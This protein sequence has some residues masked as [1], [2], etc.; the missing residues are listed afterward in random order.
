M[1]HVASPIKPYAAKPVQSQPSRPPQA[2]D[3]PQEAFAS[4][5]DDNAPETAAAAKDQDAA[6]ACAPSTPK[7]KPGKSNPDAKPA[8][9]QA[10]AKPD[11][12]DKADK[13]D[14]AEK[15]EKPAIDTNTGEAAA[16]TTD[17]AAGTEKSGSTPA[18]S[19]APVTPD[20]TAA[21]AVVPVQTIVPADAQAAATTN[22]ASAQ[23]P[24]IAAPSGQKPLD[25]AGLEG[26]A[27]KTDKVG[28][29][30]GDDP[31]ADAPQ[32]TYGEQAAGKRAAPAKPADGKTAPASDADKDHIARARGEGSDNPHR[33][34]K[35]N[36]AVQAD[37][38]AAAPKSTPDVPTP[39]LHSSSP[40]ATANAATANAAVTTPAAAQTPVPLAGVAVEIASKAMD[41]KKSFEIRLDPP[42]L[43]RI[44]VHMN[45]D[46]DGNVTSRLIADR[47]DTLDLLR[48]DSAGL[49]RAL[50][51]AGLKTSDNGLQ[52]S[53]RDQ[54]L[55]R[56]HDNGSN[57]GA[58]TARIV[59]PD[60][61][62]PLIDASA[63][64]YG[65][66]AGRG[67]GLDIRV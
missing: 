50:Q 63:Q 15:A 44:E 2:H 12:A 5:L 9:A 39:Q 61:T 48:R 52:F 8:A 62:L 27:D 66:L 3:R 22:A 23:P 14:Q 60:D 51:D 21:L 31:S 24:A 53:L 6:A 41:G 47:Q 13:S 18:P 65:R 43:G 25:P 30:A 37:A 67:G 35:E 58:R 32:T 40:A 7:A 38:G 56:Q 16:A 54:S 28:K 34:A 19:G 29:P 1:P 64:S 36:Q 57:N 42:E 46:R 10:T 55:S 20:G 11:N 59:A 17:P 49:E 45:V 26:K 33:V 4:M